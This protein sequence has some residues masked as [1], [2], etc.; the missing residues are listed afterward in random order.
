MLS[1]ISQDKTAKTKKEIGLP[2]P[3]GR[4]DSLLTAPL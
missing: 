2:S 1:L 3:Q 4:E